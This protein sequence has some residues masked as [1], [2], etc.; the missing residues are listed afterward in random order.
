MIAK[1]TQRQA[2]THRDTQAPQRT[3]EKSQLPKSL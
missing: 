3:L 2:E 1:D